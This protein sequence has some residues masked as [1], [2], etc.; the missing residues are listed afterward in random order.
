MQLLEGLVYMWIL[1]SFFLISGNWKVWPRL[2]DEAAAG[3]W[4]ACIL[5]HPLIQCQPSE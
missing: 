2:S 5:G 3:S 4:W 1:F